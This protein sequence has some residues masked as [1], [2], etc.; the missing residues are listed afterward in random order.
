MGYTT[1]LTEEQRKEFNLYAAQLVENS[2]N[3]E[4]FA[5]S[6]R[7]VANAVGSLNDQIIASGGALGEVSRT[8]SQLAENNQSLQLGYDAT[9]GKINSFSGTV[10]GSG[11]ALADAAEKPRRSSNKPRPTRLSCWS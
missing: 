11:K 5:G 7:G 1:E 2:K 3:T 10:I 8:T 6:Q 4:E 9:S